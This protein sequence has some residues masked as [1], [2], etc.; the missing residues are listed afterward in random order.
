MPDNPILWYVCT[1]NIS[2]CRERE[3]EKETE[4]EGEFVLHVLLARHTKYIVA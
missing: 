1:F 4:R 3:R 2:M